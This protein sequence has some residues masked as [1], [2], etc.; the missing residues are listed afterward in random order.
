MAEMENLALPGS[1]KNS[2]VVVEEKVRIRNHMG[3]GR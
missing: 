1:T 2:S 3:V